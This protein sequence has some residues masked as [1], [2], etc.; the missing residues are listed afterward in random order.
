[1]NP[2]EVDLRYLG[3]WDKALQ[4]TK[5]LSPGAAVRYVRSSYRL[6]SKVYHPDLHP[7]SNQAAE[8]GQRKL[9]AVKN[10]LDQAGDDELARLLTAS[11]G[12]LAGHPRL[13]V[14]DD[15]EGLRTNLAAVLSLEGYHVATAGNGVQGLRNQVSFRPELVISD[16]VMPIMDGVEMARQM[17]LRDPNLKVLFMSGFFGTPSIRSSL[18]REIED[19]ACPMISKPFK[20]SKLLEEV[21]RLLVA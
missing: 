6:L 19:L 11:L 7:E 20:P 16:V 15:E 18:V 4:I 9:N 10:R 12:P 3:V 8:D 5:E 14:V 21:R 13:L 1:L 17:R 2:L